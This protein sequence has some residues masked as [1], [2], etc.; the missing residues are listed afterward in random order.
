MYSWEGKKWGEAGFYI[1]KGNLTRDPNCLLSHLTHP[2]S[3]VVTQQCS[4]VP[5]Q[6]PGGDRLVL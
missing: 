4:T 3:R 6:V 1:L 5:S 2:V